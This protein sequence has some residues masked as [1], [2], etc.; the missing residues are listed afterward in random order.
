MAKQSKIYML[1]LFLWLAIV[2]KHWL[3]DLI[4]RYVP[5]LG[6]VRKII[7]VAEKI[8]QI[9]EKDQPGRY[10]SIKEYIGHIS[11]CLKQLRHICHRLGKTKKS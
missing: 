5:A 3:S 7:D 11:Q 9:A 4:N 1:F 8:A 10:N 6:F 2:F